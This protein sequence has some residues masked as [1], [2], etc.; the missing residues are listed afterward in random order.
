MTEEE[1]N[2]LIAQHGG[3]VGGPGNGRHI[4]PRTNTIKVKPYPDVDYTVNA[5]N[6]N[7]HWIIR[8]NNGTQIVVQPNEDGT[9]TPIST[10]RPPAQ[11]AAPKGYIYDQ[12]GQLTPVSPQTVPSAGGWVYD[13]DNP[14]HNENGYVEIGPTTSHA[15]EAG[16]KQAAE[17]EARRNA[18][19]KA[20]NDAIHQGIADAIAAGHLTDVQATN[21]WERL[22]DVLVNI[23][24]KVGQEARANEASRQTGASNAAVANIARETTAHTAGESASKDAQWIA[25]HSVG[26]QYG[27]KSGAD[28]W[29]TPTA[30]TGVLTQMPDLES[31]R[32]RTAAGVYGRLPGYGE[33]LN[34]QPA[35]PYYGGE[36]WQAARPL[37]NPWVPG[38]PLAPY[39]G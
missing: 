15:T 9:Y 17:D 33:L 12:N 1:L 7:K 14:K 29:A 26:P 2:A 22:K 23:P 30:D 18:A 4:D 19:T 5:D 28:Y 39:G 32:A 35:L 38:A 10:P 37:L 21:L 25:Q 20:Y 36:D 11:R 27:T 8:T 16:A 6:P 13:P 34:Q 24:L 31:I 3:E